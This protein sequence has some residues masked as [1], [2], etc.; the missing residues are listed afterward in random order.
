VYASLHQNLLA[1][2]ERGRIGERPRA[3]NDEVLPQVQ[4]LMQSP[5]VSTGQIC[6]RFG[7][8]KA[9]STATSVQV[10]NAADKS[11]AHTTANPVACA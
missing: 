8:S 6:E 2:R 1:V 7:I 11:P 10:A 9:R 3:L 5:E 4:A